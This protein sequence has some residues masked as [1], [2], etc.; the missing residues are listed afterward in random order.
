MNALRS[1]AKWSLHSWGATGQG[2]LGLGGIDGR[3]E[4]EESPV[5]VS[6][7]GGKEIIQVRVNQVSTMCQPGVNYVSNQVPNQVS[8]RS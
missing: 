2:R 3:S 1:G 4:A 8:V 7:L 6:A 5:V